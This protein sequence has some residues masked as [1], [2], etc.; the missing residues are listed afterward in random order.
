MIPNRRKDIIVIKIVDLWN[1]KDEPAID[2]EV[3]EHGV[4]D[5]KKSTIYPQTAFSKWDALEMA[6]TMAEHYIKCCG[7]K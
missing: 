6:R 1:D 3:Y 5:A 7:S 4:F 2:L